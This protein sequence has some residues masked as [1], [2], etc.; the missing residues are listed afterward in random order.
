MIDTAAETREPMNVTDDAQA[1]GW[2][3]T[4]TLS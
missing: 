1:G 4:V 2:T 3:Q